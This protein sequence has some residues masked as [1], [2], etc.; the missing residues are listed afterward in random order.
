M[1]LLCT[2]NETVCCA[3][4]HDIRSATQTVTDNQPLLLHFLNSVTDAFT[5]AYK[6]QVVEIRP[7]L[8]EWSDGGRPGGREEGQGMLVDLQL[9]F[10]GFEETV[11]M[12]REACFPSTSS[13]PGVES[14]PETSPLLEGDEEGLEIGGIDPVQG[15]GDPPQGLGLAVS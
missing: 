4:F 8:K 11:D 5:E 12:L 13:G 7:R 2:K 3:L 15:Q 1:Q 9:P 6:T 14:P 10:R